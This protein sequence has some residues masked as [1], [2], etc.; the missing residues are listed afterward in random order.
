MQSLETL[1]QQNT[2][3]IQDLL[4]HEVSSLA[5]ASMLAN[6]PE[7]EPILQAIENLLYKRVVQIV[8]GILEDILAQISLE[9][10][11]AYN[12]ADMRQTVQLF[13][14]EQVKDLLVDLRE[15]VKW[16]KQQTTQNI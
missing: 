15:K 11:L 4:H 3:G 8:Q 2:K 7:T 14:N 13:V 10:S 16:W 1:L 12:M 5:L 9:E 6:I